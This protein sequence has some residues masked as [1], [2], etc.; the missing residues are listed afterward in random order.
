MSIT[1]A[2]SNAMSGLT[3]T[4]RGTETVAANL[5]NAMTPNYARREIT[6]SAQ[7]LGGAFGGVRV[8]GVT[9]I[10]NASVLAEKRA[11]EGVRSGSDTLLAFHKAMEASVG[12]AGSAG[13]IGS[14]LT[15]FQ[16]ALSSAASRPEDE[17]RLTQAVDAAAALASRLNSASGAV[18]RAR[19]DADH[20]IAADVDALNSGL[21]Q[22]AY[23]NRR[24]AA[25][26]ADGSNTSSLM[27][28]RQAVVDAITKIVPVHEVVRE[29]G[30]IALFTTGGAA[31]LDGTQPVAFSF[32]A[33]VGVTWGSHVNTG[34]LSRISQNGTD[35]T[36]SQ[37]QLFSG[38][39]LSANFAIRDDLAPAL[40]KE[41][42]AL[43]FDLHQR[44]A[45]GVDSTVG[46]TG[47][48]FFTDAGARADP[49]SVGGL[50]A[51]IALNAGLQPAVGGQLWRLRAG[52]GA[53]SPGPVGD[54]A[55]IVAISKA[56]GD[57]TAAVPGSGFAGNGSLSDRFGVVE[58][59]VATRRVTAELDATS[60]NSFAD[61]IS[62]RFAE[63]GVDRDAETSRLLE[64]EQIYAANA[65]VIQAVQ[66]MMDQILRL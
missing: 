14:A 40:Q 39:T 10:V 20:A 31:L 18:Q 64:Y 49:A 13:G 54:G 36:D 58:S 5:A 45:I 19:A 27:D 15:R 8:D 60:Q 11:A 30:K 59:R 56:L 3:A 62:L 61:T 25:L 37:M 47:A 24:I 46:P 16:T 35:L 44:L 17:V 38:G 12:I 63:D 41:L 1:K 22:V 9:R 53:T 29:A 42:D 52:I 4:S 50:S 21:E 55:L 26:H 65:R 33:A 51:R 48:A 23:L 2:L 32:N 34:G 7:T 66:E 6:L 57:V 43:A 28:A